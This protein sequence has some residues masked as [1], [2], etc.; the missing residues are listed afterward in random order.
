MNR[1]RIIMLLT[2]S[3]LSSTST[4]ADTTSCPQKRGE[5]YCSDV[6][7]MCNLK[8][9]TAEGESLEDETKDCA[10]FPLPVEEIRKDKQV[11]YTVFGG[12]AAY[13]MACAKHVVRVHDKDRLSAFEYTQ[14]F[15]VLPPYV[16]FESCEG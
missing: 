11:I 14:E 12:L 5:I 4:F 1:L 13:S 16:R 10:D 3:A 9:K 8:L 15:F 6:V 7:P 2:I